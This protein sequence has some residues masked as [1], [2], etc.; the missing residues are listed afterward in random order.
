MAKQKHSISEIAGIIENEGL[1]Y[2]IQSYIKAS[3]IKDEDLADMWERAKELLDEIE[4]YVEDN[5]DDVDDS[6]DDE[7]GDDEDY[8]YDD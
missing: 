7:D 6:T 8:G 2:A 5:A 4:E 3:S 1:G